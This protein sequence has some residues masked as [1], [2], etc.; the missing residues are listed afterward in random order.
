MARFQCAL[1]DTQVLILLLAPV[2]GPA[3]FGD[4]ILECLSEHQKLIGYVLLP[5]SRM[6]NALISF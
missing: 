3:L 4:H 2:A 6:P 1:S 5:S